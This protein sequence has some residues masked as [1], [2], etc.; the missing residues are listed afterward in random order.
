M[1]SE[2]D[3]F[4]TSVYFGTL[5]SQWK[6][7]SYL[8]N[9]PLE[10]YMQDLST[11]YAFIQNWMDNGAPKIFPISNFFHPRKFLTGRIDL[12]SFH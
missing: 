4:I 7:H 1:T 9:K 5:P 12:D 3:E 2:L 8:S 10:S 6:E 11:R